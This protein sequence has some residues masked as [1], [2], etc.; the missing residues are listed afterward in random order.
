MG[1]SR[2]IPEILIQFC[3]KSWPQPLRN[4]GENIS[5][6]SFYFYILILQKLYLF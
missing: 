6:N 3:G 4:L 5:Q 1:P 2:P